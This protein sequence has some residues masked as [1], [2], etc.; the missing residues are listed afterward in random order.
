M[1]KKPDALRFIHSSRNDVPVALDYELESRGT[2]ALISLLVPALRTLSAGGVLIVDE[3]ESSLHPKLAQAFV[4]LFTKRNS[5]SQGAQLIFS[6]HDVALLG[7]NLLQRDEVWLTDKTDEGVSRFT[8]LSDFKLRRN[9]DIEKAYRRGRFRA[10]PGGDRFS[11]DT[12]D[13]GIPQLS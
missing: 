10:V 4:T 3:L 2:L 13:D 8:P 9:D 5:N 12:I 7:S 11:M 1:F 6:T